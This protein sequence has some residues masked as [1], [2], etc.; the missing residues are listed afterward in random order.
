MSCPGTAHTA[1]IRYAPREARHWHWHSVRSAMSGTDIQHQVY[2]RPQRF[3]RLW[4]PTGKV[5]G[6]GGG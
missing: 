2:N 6:G 5:A 1:S 3:C 4:E